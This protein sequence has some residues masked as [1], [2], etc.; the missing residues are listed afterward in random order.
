[1]KEQMFFENALHR[2]LKHCWLWFWR[3]LERVVN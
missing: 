2:Y 3:S 1:M